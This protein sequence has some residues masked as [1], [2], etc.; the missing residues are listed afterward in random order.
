MSQANFPDNPIFFQQVSC[1]CISIPSRTVGWKAILADISWYHGHTLLHCVSNLCCCI[2]LSSGINKK[3]ILDLF[4]S[5]CL[6]RCVIHALSSSALKQ[7]PNA[8]Q[9]AVTDEHCHN[10]SC[11]AHARNCFS[12]KSF[13]A[14][15][16]NLIPLM[17][18]GHK[19]VVDQVC[20]GAP[21]C[22]AVKALLKQMCESNR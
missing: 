14:E 1:I 15:R 4:N 19:V 12:R 9:A 8:V 13:Q 11:D 22:L 3:E 21:S 5:C 2:Q 7:P 6:K 17:W 16:P 18:D 10:I 20:A